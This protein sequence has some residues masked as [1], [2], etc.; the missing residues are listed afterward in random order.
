ML[1]KAVTSLAI[2]AAVSG[3][4]MP[5]PQADA[6]AIYC[7]NCSSRV[8]QLLQHAQ[9]ARQI[10]MQVQQLQMEVARYEQMARDVVNLPE[11]MMSG[12]IQDISKIHAT[13]EQG[14]ALAY[15]V[16]NLDQEFAS[17]YG[18]LDRYRNSGFNA[19]Q[20][21]GKYEQWDAETTDGLKGVYRTL[22]L[23]AQGMVDEQEFMNRLRQRSQSAQGQREV[24]TV[25]HELALEGIAQMQRLRQLL[26][27][28]MQQEAQATQLQQ[29]QA[30]V[31]AALSD[32]F[33][34]A[35]LDN[36]YK[37]KTY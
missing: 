13:I 36:S 14:R 10:T 2:I 29:D 25:G 22:G 5:A 3:V 11:T 28:Q 8:T 18:S 33:F 6:Q 1:R 24:A 26:M 35:E 32:R 17:R 19:G 16:K 15:T 20:L 23:Q 12:V 7:T 27:V 37:A 31:S 34:G 21:A 4:A 9:Q 30:A